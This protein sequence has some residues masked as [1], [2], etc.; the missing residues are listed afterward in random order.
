M[1]LPGTTLLLAL[2]VAC[3]SGG[4]DGADNPGP[5]PPPPSNPPGG[6]SGSATVTMNSTGDGYG[7]ESHTFA[8]GQVSI[9]RSGT[10]TWSNSTGVLHNVTFSSASAPTSIENFATG[11]RSR[12]FPDAGTWSYTCSNH[13]GMNGSVVVAP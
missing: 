8:P 5:T 7:G 6:P 2:V 9:V 10:V 4:D 1:R 12:S 11:E 3:S 13:A